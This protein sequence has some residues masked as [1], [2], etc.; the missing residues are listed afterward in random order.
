VIPF[1][2]FGDIEKKKNNGNNCS[3][4]SL[5][6]SDKRNEHKVR[7]ESINQRGG[8]TSIY[9]S[10]EMR[11]ERRWLEKCKKENPERKERKEEAKQRKTQEVW[12]ASPS[13]KKWRKGVR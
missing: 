4:A 5:L 2:S 7:R 8:A 10:G 12:N 11:R 3:S 9:R 6:I 13:A 1:F